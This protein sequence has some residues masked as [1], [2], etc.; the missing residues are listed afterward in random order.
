M[1]STR[2]RLIACHVDVLKKLSRDPNGPNSEA[3]KKEADNLADHITRL[4]AG[5]RS[6]VQKKSRG[7]PPSPHPTLPAHSSQLLGTGQDHDGGGRGPSHGQGRAPIVPG[8]GA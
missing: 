3:L 5:R 4:N 6:G 8:Q 2:D 1:S 7:D